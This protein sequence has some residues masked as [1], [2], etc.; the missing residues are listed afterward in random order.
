MGFGLGQYV[1]LVLYVLM[2]IVFFITIFF[3]AQYGLYLLL[4]LSPLQTLRY[5]MH[6]FPL[7]ENFIQ[8]L[9]CGVL[10]AFLVRR[11]ELSVPKTRL[12]MLVGI[13][14]IYIYLSMWMGTF[15]VGGIGVPLFPN[16]VRCSD[17]INYAILPLIYFLSLAVIRGKREMVVLVVLLAL[18]MLFVNIGFRRNTKSRDMSNFSYD[19][20]TAG[21]M[22]WTGVN[23]LGAFEAQYMLFLIG[24]FATKF[25]SRAALRLPYYALLAFSMYT[26]LYTFSRGS[27]LAF[28]LGIVVLGLMKQ[29]KYLIA[30]AV[31]SLTWTVVVPKAV[32][33]RILMTYSEDTGVESSAEE[34]LQLWQDG[35][36][37]VKQNPVLG[38][39]YDTYKFLRAD[40]TLRDTHNMFMKALVETGIV[41]LLFYVAVLLVATHTAWRLY[42]DTSDPFFKAFGLATFIC[43][44][45]VMV[46][47]MFGDRWTY[48]EINGF[49]WALLG[50]TARARHIVAEEKQRTQPEEQPVRQFEF[51]ELPAGH[52]L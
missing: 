14:F 1:P 52:V 27:Y 15:R 36:E 23:G 5:K 13:W 8:I 48:M 19:V 3:R 26:L 17:F 42:A 11:K 9:A 40:E 22:G 35:I 2:W 49:L 12:A 34:R 6:Q 32:Q 45:A 20:R 41:G 16:D 43:M 24:L 10:I 18:S 29:R 37:R 44:L 39:G 28:L 33:Q 4:L 30:I 21:F 47:N 51:A 50:A 31:L 38:S 25:N 46:S 7:G